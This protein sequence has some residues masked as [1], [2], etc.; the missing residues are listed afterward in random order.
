MLSVIGFV[1]VD[2]DEK[3][4]GKHGAFQKP[5]KNLREVVSFVPRSRICPVDFIHGPHHTD[6]TIQHVDLQNPV[7]RPCGSY[8]ILQGRSNGS[9]IQQRIPDVSSKKNN[10]G[11]RHIGASYYEGVDGYYFIGKDGDLRRFTDFTMQIVERQILHRIDGSDLKRVLLSLHGVKNNTFDIV[12][13]DEKWN[14]LPGVIAKKA[15]LCQLFTD[16]VPN[17]TDKLRRLSG[18]LLQEASTRAKEIQDFWGWSKPAKDG[19]R[20]F[21]HGG[22]TDCT[23][24]KSLPAHI[25]DCVIEC[26]ILQKA[27]KIWDVGPAEVVYPLVLYSAASYMDALFTDAGYPLA[28]CLMLVGTS[29][30]MKTTFFREIYAVFSPKKERIKSVRGTEASFNVL[31]QEALDDT[32]V[33]DDFNRE[34]SAKEIAAKMKTMRALIR[35]YSDKTPRTKYGG[36][37]N[38]TSYAIRGGCVF[39]GETQMIGEL[40]SGILRYFKIHLEQPFDGKCLGEFQRNPEYMKYLLG[41]F[42][43]YLE[44]NYLLLVQNIKR[45]FPLM[46]EKFADMGAPRIVDALIQLGVVAEVMEAFIVSTGA[47]STLNADAWCKKSQEI[48]YRLA[49]HQATEASEEEPY[50]GYLAEIWNLLGTGRIFIAKNLEAYLSDLPHYI[51]YRDGDLYMLKKDEVYQQV[52]EAYRLRGDYLTLGVDEISK[53]LKKQNIT[54][55]D[56]NSCLK[57]TSS[58]LPG[59]PRMLAVIIDECNKLLR[60]K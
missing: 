49:R 35:A 24:R 39:T 57:K 11:V 58:R 52:R 43:L 23:A 2:K 21:Y 25:E 1:D 42:I 46:R 40:Q 20:I 27:W 31:H 51:G 29:G 38:V 28:H 7:R 8:S 30:L 17:V 54:K 15:P 18:I 41:S 3:S 19:G 14:D 5:E 37:D 48:L 4:G 9:V 36:K 45:R 55:T 53:I 44:R 33:V 13:S 16:T 47:V 10:F 22:R 60:G 26:D 50:V 34:G 6:G 32:L 12:I 56:T 59:R